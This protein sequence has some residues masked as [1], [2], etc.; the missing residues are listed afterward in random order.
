MNGPRARARL[1][2][3]D[4]GPTSPPFLRGPFSRIE[5]SRPWRA[6]DLRP[7]LAVSRIVGRCQRMCTSLRVCI[8]FDDSRD[9]KNHFGHDVAFLLQPVQQYVYHQSQKATKGQK[10]MKNGFLER[11]KQGLDVLQRM[12]APYLSCRAS[13]ALSILSGVVSTQT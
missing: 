1:W 8:R 11:S 3:G 2:H 13:R 5:R 7:V 4:R 9:R 10:H 6:A 12:D